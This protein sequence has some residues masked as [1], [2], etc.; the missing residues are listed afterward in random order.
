MEFEFN[1]SGACGLS[2][3]CPQ[4][5]CVD[6]SMLHG[7]RG[8]DLSSVFD[9]MGENS[10]R[11]QGLKKAVTFGAPSLYG[12]KVYLLVHGRHCMG[13]LKTG[14]KRLFITPPSLNS[15]GKAGVQ[16]TLTEIEPM[17]VLD[18]YVS[19]A[20]QRGGYGKKIFDFMLSHEGMHPARLAYDRPSEKLLG[21][22]RKHFG[23]CKFRPQNNNFVVFDEFFRH[24][25]K[26]PLAGSR[27]GK[28]AR[29]P[30]FAGG[31]SM[32]ASRTGASSLGRDQRQFQVGSDTADPLAPGYGGSSGS[33]QASPMGRS[34]YSSDQMGLTREQGA[35]E[36]QMPPPTLGHPDG[37]GGHQMMS[38]H[39]PGSHHNMM[40][41]QGSRQQLIS[42]WATSADLP[43]PLP[44]HGRISGAQDFRR[45][46]VTP[47][48][49]GAPP[50]EVGYPMNRTPYCPGLSDQRGG[51][52]S[53]NIR[54]TPWGT[55]ADEYPAA[56]RAS[57]SCGRRSSS[58]PHAMASRR[59]PLSQGSS[60]SRFGSPL[61]RA[62]HNLLAQGVW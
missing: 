33:R 27:R 20:V 42:P 25:Q 7:P 48:C 8:R 54:S 19:E 38:Q 14:V 51:T 22:L 34:G 41:Q 1:V 16:D 35:L 32:R 4:V 29:D 26:P 45:N 56:G 17:C 57:G 62:G 47:S 5:A 23:L 43:P 28:D 30:P 49:A 24:S 12:Q 46:Q 50:T 21:F 10:R 13:L 31:P 60:A 9:V 18:F 3:D 37:I 58:T 6:D 61:C 53:S 15:N 11:A 2:A 52:G 59:D 55:D 40:P 44:R 36:L 39:V